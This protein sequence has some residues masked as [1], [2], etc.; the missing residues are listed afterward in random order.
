MKKVVVIVAIA[1]LF[2]FA[3]TGCITKPPTEDPVREQAF[4]ENII[5]NEAGN[6][7]EIDGFTKGKFAYSY[8]LQPGWQEG[9]LL[10]FYPIKEHHTDIVHIV[11]LAE[12]PG[13]VV[14]TV[15]PQIAG[16]DQIIT[17]Y[18]RIHVYQ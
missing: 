10:E 2:A 12:I 4:L 13:T 11:P 1:V 3:F 17:T 8:T 6:V 5:V 16:Q 7:A 9:D 15:R 14:I 18:Y